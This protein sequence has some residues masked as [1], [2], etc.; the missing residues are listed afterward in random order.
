MTVGYSETLCGCCSDCGVCCYVL[1]CECTLIPSAQNWAG[2]MRDECE[3]CHCCGIASPIW[4]RSNIRT[5]NGVHEPHYCGDG[6][7]YCL[8]FALATCQDARELK[9]LRE[10]LGVPPLPV[11]TPVAAVGYTVTPGHGADQQPFAFAPPR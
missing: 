4:T 1:L 2:S 6:C 10:P 11:A 7:T 5:L 9:R 3:L 8:C